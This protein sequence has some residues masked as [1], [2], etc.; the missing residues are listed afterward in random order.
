MGARRITAP[1]LL[2]ALTLV[3]GANLVAVV[4]AAPPEAITS[5]TV[6][7]LA[8]GV[9]GA[10]SEP[11]REPVFVRI[12]TADAWWAAAG[13]VLQLHKHRVP[14]RV[15]RRLDWLFGERRTM[16]EGIPR[17]VVS[18]AQGADAV[19]LA[20]LAGYRLVAEAGGVSAFVSAPDGAVAP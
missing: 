20:A 1:V 12:V 7:A 3:A 2:A 10:L 16:R 15:E 5:P 14:V 8:G 6:E 13:V 17:A 19:R 18:I 11:S 4:R 9:R